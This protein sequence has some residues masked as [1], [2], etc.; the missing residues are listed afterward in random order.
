[1]GSE[2]MTDAKSWLLS[3]M[4]EHDFTVPC[5]AFNKIAAR[6]RGESEQPA[7][8]AGD[9]V[10]SSRLRAGVECAPWVIDEVRKMEAALSAAPAAPDMPP[11]GTPF[12]GCQC[13]TCGEEF[14]AT[15]APAPV[16]GDADRGEIAICLQQRNRHIDIQTARYYVDAVLDALAQDRESQGAAVRAVL[17]APH[18]VGRAGEFGREEIV[19][20]AR[21]IRDALEGE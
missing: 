21:R 19:V 14:A 2:Q 9:A 3:I 13:P 6:L 12:V 10:L 7:A 15:A 11:P 17:D 4:G 18:N 1:M 16:A 8:V 20:S 5:K